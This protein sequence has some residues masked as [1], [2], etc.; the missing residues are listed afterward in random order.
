MN[1]VS[2]VLNLFDFTALSE[3]LRFSRSNIPYF[4]NYGFNGPTIAAG[5]NQTKKM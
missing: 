2:T 4:M 5:K 1:M 3:I